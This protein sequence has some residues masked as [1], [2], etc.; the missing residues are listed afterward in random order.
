VIEGDDLFLEEFPV[1]PRSSILNGWVFALFGL[2]DIGLAFNNSCAWSYFYRSLN[3]LKKTTYLR[4]Y[5]S[6][7]VYTSVYW[8]PFY[9]HLH[10]KQ[11]GSSL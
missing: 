10:V 3:T 5:W 4:G 11:L 2:Y 7:Y 9:H 6:Y 1:L 8:A